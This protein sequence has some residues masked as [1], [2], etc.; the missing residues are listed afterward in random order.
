MKSNHI[1]T[2]AVIAAIA[3]LVGWIARNTYW[4]EYTIPMPPKGEALT[5]SLYAA[6]RLAEALGVTVESRRALGTLPDEGSLIYLSYWNWNL[7]PTRREQLE[8]WVERGGRLVMDSSLIGGEE[9]IEQW[10]GI[11]RSELPSK[12]DI[13]DS[14]TATFEDSSAE[15]CATLDV[16][17]AA[18]GR[19][20]YDVCNIELRSRLT[21]RRP[22]SWLLSDEHGIHA[23]R[24]EVG[25]GSV[26]I[27]NADPFRNQSLFQGDDALLFVAA[28]QLERGDRFY[29]L[30]EEISP[31][32]L[33][34]MWMYGAP[35]IALALGVILLALWRG[36][37]RFGPPA[38]ITDPARRS[39]AEQILGT[40]RFTVRFGGGRALHGAVVR[41]LHEAAQRQISGYRDLQ[42]DARIAA[43]AAKTGLDAS[44][45]AESINYVGR[46]RTDELRRAVT[47][48]ETARRRII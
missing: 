39:L 47:L 29:L 31:S 44:A 37:L 10:I 48:L 12:E 34:L 33:Q 6:Q 41:A 1:I 43:L 27:L 3:L 11:E 32:L 21:S 2:V 13:A 5:N 17:S 30:S 28:T 24:L 35:V 16:E 40:G 7:I 15:K 14:E 36:S 46:R 9:Q 18:G 26:T 19:A 4:D 8:Q 38:G 45:L 23:A 42:D 22:S 25:R 20:S